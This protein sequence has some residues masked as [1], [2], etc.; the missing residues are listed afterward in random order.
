MNHIQCDCVT[1]NNKCDVSGMVKPSRLGGLNNN[2]TG[3]M[4]NSIDDSDNACGWNDNVNNFDNIDSE[5][6]S[7]DGLGSLQVEQARQIIQNY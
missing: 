4:Y 6:R 7:S 2:N 3:D 5:G 1:N